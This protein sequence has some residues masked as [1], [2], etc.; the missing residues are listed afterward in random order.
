MRQIWQTGWPGSRQGQAAGDQNQSVTVVGV[1]D[2]DVHASLS[3]SARNRAELARRA[4][5][6]LADD[7]F[8][9][10]HDFDPGV[11]CGT[12]GGSAITE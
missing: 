3:Q 5:L 11:L 10:R 9:D 1:L 2:K 7:G 12:G 8:T 6:Q 4:L